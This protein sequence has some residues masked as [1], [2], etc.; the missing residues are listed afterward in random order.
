MTDA[1]GLFR[2]LED[3]NPL[4]FKDQRQVALVL[5]TAALDAVRQETWEEAIEIVESEPELEGLMP[6]GVR[7]ALMSL[8]LEKQQRS[9][10]RVTKRSIAKRCR[11]QAKAVEK[12]P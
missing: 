8:S 4:A 12:A 1:T 7:A 6:D 10:V 2:K 11:A 9:A 3:I 5:L